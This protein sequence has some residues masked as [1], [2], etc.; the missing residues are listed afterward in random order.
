MRKEQL[1]KRKA[2]QAAQTRQF[3]IIMSLL[4][5]ALVASLL[6]SVFVIQP[7]PKNQAQQ[8][9]TVH[10]TKND[11]EVKTKAKKTKYATITASGDM[12]YHDIVYR[13]AED[14]QGYDF[15]NDYAQISPLLKKADLSLGD[16]EGTINPER[17]LSGYP[18][19]NAPTAAADA[20]K[21]AGFDVIDLAHNHILDTGLEGLHSTV[22]AFQNI[23]LDTIGVKTDTTEDILVKEVN[24]IKIALLAYAY[25]FN[26]MEAT[27]TETEYE[28]HLKDLNMEK[29][30]KDLKKAEKIAD[31]TIVMPQDGV[32]YALEPNEEQQTK[33]RQMIDLGADIIF[34]GHPHVA[35]PT[36]TIKKDGENKF[37]IYSMGNLLSNQRYESVEN[38]WTERGVIMEVAIKKANDKT[39]I[40]KVIAHPTWVDREPIAGRS[41]QD[42][43]Y[44]TVQ[45]QDY[46]VF[47]AE[48][49]LP[50]GKYAKSVPETKRKRIE[51]AYHEMNDLLKIDWK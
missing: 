2:Q 46:Q 32:E 24:G 51:T 30:A 9:N 27:I 43:I 28:N 34:G 3:I 20:I 11:K 1:Q 38:Y 48:N 47:L 14:G 18:M 36:E 21:E 42:A 19:F 37:I 4:F 17:E 6:L 23:E 25:G 40:E 13:S 26:G 33:Y 5:A 41:Y 12:L 44:G 15:K 10:K 39:T 7:T 31:I 16:F 45:S 22:A 29:V 49:Y 35:E 50:G 8:T